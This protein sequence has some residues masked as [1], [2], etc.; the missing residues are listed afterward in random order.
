[1]P[2]VPAEDFGAA[3]VIRRYCDRCRKPITLCWKG[4][5]KEF[6]T[7]ACRKAYESGDT[8]PETNT[9]TVTET[10]SPIVAGAPAAAK[11]KKT[12]KPT[13]KKAA[14]KPP[15]KAKPTPKAA[16]PAK[17]SNGARD[18]NGPS[19][20]AEASLEALKKGNVSIA[21]LMKDN[22][23]SEGTTRTQVARLKR[24]YN[25]T[26]TTTTKGDQQFFTFAK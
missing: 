9:E 15:A 22:E 19:E 3:G 12:A 13:A 16:K 26:L 23:W 21:K 18:P 20:K 5:G 8:M 2:H 24:K 11:P 4:R 1:M 10:P 7:N 17:S 25:L 14:A 6:C